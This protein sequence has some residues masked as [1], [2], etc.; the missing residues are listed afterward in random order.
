MRPPHG[1]RC[2]LDPVYCDRIVRRWQVYSK[3]DALLA[4]KTFEQMQI[5]RRENSLLENAVMTPSLIASIATVPSA[6]D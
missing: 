2:E 3:D 6:V 5:Q 1:M 4:G